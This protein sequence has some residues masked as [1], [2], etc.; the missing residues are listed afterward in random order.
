MTAALSPYEGMNVRSLVQTQALSRPD[1][2]AIIWEPFS[3]E[4]RAWTYGELNADLAAF[5]AGLA[6]R[7]VRAGQRVLIHL[8]NCPELV[9]AWLGCAYLGAVAVTTNTRSS[10]EEL[11]Y[12]AGHSQVV[13]AITQPAYAEIVA[14]AA[15]EL[16]WLAITSTDAGEA[17]AWTP[18]GSESFAALL[19]AADDLPPMPADPWASFAIQYTSGTT[20]RPK[21]VLWTHGNALWGGQASAEHE[22][23]RPDDVH[24]VTLPLYHTNA[25]SYSLLASLWVGATVVIQPRFSASRFWDVSLRRRCTWTSMIPFCNRAL[26]AQP[27][28]DW[29]HY[30]L[31]GNAISSP[32]TDA[33]F[34][35]K[36]IGWWGMTE[37]VTHG[38]VASANLPNPT[39]SIGRPARGYDVKVVD[40]GGRPV[41]A[42]ESG[43]LLIQGRRGVSLFA[44][45]A[46]DPA[47][48]AA[49]FDA[50]GFFLTG[51]RVYRDASGAMFF[52][53]R[54][55]DMLKVGGENVAASEIERVVG[56]VPGVREVAVVAARDPMLDEV[57]V[58]FVIPTAEASASH[59]IAAI[60][61]AC[62]H[63]LATFKQPRQVRL[64]EALPR[65]TLEKVAKARLRELLSAEAAANSSGA[66]A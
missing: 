48:T 31:W 44:G 17:P 37:T 9:I 29:H 6:K 51:D 60:N 43:D 65:S 19:G 34:G 23:L 52:A 59:L 32:P 27:S 8:D 2:P 61:A 62:V 55:K 28:P 42:G 14:A 40:D 46:G 1:H 10:R 16:K 13:G 4:A 12:F 11:A 36:T 26:M 3:G 53:D 56:A 57:P 54:S 39:R 7:G 21:A 35:V 58:A 45:Y 66:P 50:E 30:R 41:G 63:S 22:G 5:A 47:A 15:T 24:L 25:Q 18:G 38:L 49:A 20:S 64:V 33:V